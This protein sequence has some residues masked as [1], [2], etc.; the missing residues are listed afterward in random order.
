MIE[1]LKNY[2]DEKAKPPCIL[3][4]NNHGLDNLRLDAKHRIATKSPLQQLKPLQLNQPNPTQST[5]STQ[6]LYISQ[7]N[8][9]FAPTINRV[10]YA[11]ILFT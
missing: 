7:N 5:Y 4:S 11:L 6:H 10:I 2:L 1:G 8:L 9:T 3:Q